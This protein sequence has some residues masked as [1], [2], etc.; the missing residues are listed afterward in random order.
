MLVAKQH[1]LNQ[2]NAISGHGE[3]WLAAVCLR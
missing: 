3:H 1:F 2:G